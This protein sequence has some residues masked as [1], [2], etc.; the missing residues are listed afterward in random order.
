MIEIK[1][2]K[3]NYQKKIAGT[4]FELDIPNWTVNDGDFVG[5]LGPNGCGKSTL[6]RL[7]CNLSDPKEGTI[8]INQKNICNLERK[9]I[10]KKI[11]YVPQSTQSIFPFSVY[12]IILM[13]RTPYLNMM[14]FE[15]QKDKDI[16]SEAMALMEIEHLKLKGINELS[17]GEAQ[18][19]FIARA[20]AQK[21]DVILLDEP[22]AH[23]DIEHQIKI[24]DILKKINDEE[25]KTIISVSHDLNLVGIYSKKVTFIVNGKIV[26]HGDKPEMLNESNI[27][28]IFGINSKIFTSGSQEY[29]NVLINPVN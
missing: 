6:L 28:E 3:F 19:V 26:L 4:G 2:L 13:G 18:R 17:G 27:R 24:F 16:V 8:E 10:A 7:L 21:A 12:E 1:N 25:G 5:L 29:L 9:E 15:N 20:L 23:L 22:N 11:A 14:G